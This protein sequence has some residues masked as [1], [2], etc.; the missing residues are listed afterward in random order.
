MTRTAF[1]LIR[2]A[3]FAAP[4][5]E[6]AIHPGWSPHTKFRV[7]MRR[8]TGLD[9]AHPGGPKF[10]WGWLVEGWGG[11]VAACATTYGIPKL[12]SIIRRL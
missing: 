4:A 6:A 10:N 2:L 7:G 8:Y 5:V 11:Y 3:A 12:V 9:L 1:K